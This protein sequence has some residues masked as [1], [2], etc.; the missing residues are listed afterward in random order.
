MDGSRESVRRALSSKTVGIAGV[1]GLGSNCAHALA[2]AGVGR[3]VIVDFDTVSREN[4]DRQFFFLDQI[5]MPKVDALAAN[6]ARIDPAVRVQAVN[7]RIEASAV[8]QIFSGCDA[9]VEALDDAETK[10]LFIEAVLSSMPSLP[11]VAGSGIA[12]W[13]ASDDI[14]V[15][16]MGSFVL[17]GDQCREVGQHHAPLAARVCAV[18]A[19]QANEVLALL[20]GPMDEEE[21]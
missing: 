21:A 12:G 13:G 2:R 3:L 1:G 17:V 18:A 6:L 19:I 4:L 8:R 5:G 20:L 9:V 10:A 11:L 7:A 14:R 16:R 15:R